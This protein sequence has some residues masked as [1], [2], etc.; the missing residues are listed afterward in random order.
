MMF[1]LGLQEIMIVVV[2]GTLGVGGLGVLYL[3]V[4][5]TMRAGVRDSKD[6]K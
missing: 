6:N 5:A 3:V 1:G 2:I 4:R